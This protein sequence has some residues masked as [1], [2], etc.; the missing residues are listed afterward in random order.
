MTRQSIP[1]APKSSPVP[2]SHTD[3]LIVGAGPTGL[4][5][6]AALRLRGVAVTVIDRQPQG[7]NT[8]RAAVVH[9]RTLEVLETIGA[10]ERLDE[11]GIAAPRF[12]IRDRD[13]VLVDLRFDDLPTRYPYSLM[14][15]QAVTERVLHDRLV[16]LGGQVLRPRMLVGVTQ[17]SGGVDALLDD[18]SRVRARYLVGADGMHSTVREQ[19]QIG[20]GGSWP[21]TD[22]TFLEVRERA[23]VGS[24]GISASGMRVGSAM[25]A[26]VG[27]QPASSSQPIHQNSRFI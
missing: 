23:G 19:A 20:R 24:A 4:T 22:C 5:L 7:S 3:V 6:A 1:S 14:V 17:D 16:A 12:T 26:G 25:T 2:P 10:A 27:A 13:R 18:G 21:K 8:S 9:A 11:L 15:S